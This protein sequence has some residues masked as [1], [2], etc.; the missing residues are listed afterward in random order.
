M[1]QGKRKRWLW[2]LLI[3]GI[4]AAILCVLLLPFALMAGSQMMGALIGPVN[5]WNSTSK[6]PAEA[7]VEG[8]YQLSKPEV[9]NAGN[10]TVRIPGDSGFVLR[11]NHELEVHDLPKFDGFGS[12]SGCA[13]NGTG[14]WSLDPNPAGVVLS[15]NITTVLPAGTGDLPS[16]G[17]EYFGAFSVLG[18]SKPYR[19]W[20]VI[21]DP[22]SDQGL[23]YK[24]R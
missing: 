4:P 22:D 10:S 3:P 13:Y 14:R 1:P 8:Q 5:V 2:L 12:S 9:V 20:Y 23:L 19:F 7:D 16:C 24:L 18:H 11:A 21:G 6:V 17:P 15:L